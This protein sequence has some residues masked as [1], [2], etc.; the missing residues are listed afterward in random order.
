MAKKD[1]AKLARNIRR[2]I[3][4]SFSKKRMR[5]IGLEAIE[6]IVARTRK[7]QGVKR[8]G[9]RKARLKRLSSNYIAYRRSQN[10]DSTTSAGK[11]NLTFTGQLLRSMVVKT[12]SNR[13][14]TWG[15]NRRRRRG[16][17]TNERLGEIVSVKRPFNFLSSREISRLAKSI[18][19]NLSRQLGKI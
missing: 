3:G 17:L 18:D 15:P 4:V 19:K 12:N 14:V 11:S 13:K 8:T 5:D 16:G 9:G 7:G 1:L 6:I 2:G 10:L